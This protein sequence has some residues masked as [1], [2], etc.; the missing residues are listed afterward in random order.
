MYTY[1]DTEHR[2]TYIFNG[3]ISLE[4]NGIAG[5]SIQVKYIVRTY[6]CIRTSVQNANNII[7][8]ATVHGK[9]LAG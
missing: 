6:L 9:I 4:D 5:L 1:V 2:S 3:L 7:L 8:L